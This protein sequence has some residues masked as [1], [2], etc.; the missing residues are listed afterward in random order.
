MLTP[1]VEP[2]Q[3][4]IALKIVEYQLK[5]NGF[6]TLEQMKELS[7]GTGLP[8]DDIR[9]LYW[10][11]LPKYLGELFDYQKVVVNMTGPNK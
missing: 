2:M 10:S 5:T 4:H 9:G 6:P 7:A 1:E 11:V 3:G 8:L